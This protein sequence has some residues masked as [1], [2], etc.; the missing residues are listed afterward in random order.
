[1]MFGYARVSTLDQQ[2]D[3]QIDMLQAFG[4]ETI[5]R[6]KESGRSIARRTQFQALL[7]R[8]T[9]GDTVVVAKLDR[10]ARSTQDALN[11]VATLTDRG[12]SLVVLNMGG[13]VVDTSTAIGK[14]MLTMLS[15]IAEFEADL[16]HERQRE[17]IARA[18][19]RG[20]YKG[21][22][23][24]YT[25]HHRGLRHAIQ[26]FQERDKNHFTVNDIAAMTGISR[27]SIYRHIPNGERT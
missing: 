9:A 17:G 27:A 18:K 22:P 11:T 2:L 3:G 4:C 6:E 16:I 15:G 10:L 5:F 25:V 24:T 19:A 26:L 1:M 20:V 13:D 8:V 23:R 21:R 14:L 7:E 12:V